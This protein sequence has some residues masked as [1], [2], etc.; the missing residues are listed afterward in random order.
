MSAF[1]VVFIGNKN[2]GK[3]SIV[4][5]NTGDKFSEQVDRQHDRRI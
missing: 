3:T 5:R 2:V 4:N 1:K